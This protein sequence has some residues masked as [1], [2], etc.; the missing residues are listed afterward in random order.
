M[1]PDIVYFSNGNKGSESFSVNNKYHNPNGPAYI[2][3]YSNGNK[4]YEAYWL[5]GERHNTNGPAVVKYY[6]NGNKWY[7]QYWVNGMFH[8]LNGPS[9]IL[10]YEDGFVGYK[11]YYVNSKRIEPIWFSE[12]GYDIEKDFIDK[13]ILNKVLSKH[14][15]PS[16]IKEIEEYITYRA[17]NITVT[18]TDDNS[19]IKINDQ[20]LNLSNEEITVLIKILQKII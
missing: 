7:E 13:E 1:K 8:N 11:S 2:G 3:Y 16:I 18:K 19:E 15:L 20:T 10:Y 17:G 4:S 14:N 12:L 6:E 9:D 5:N